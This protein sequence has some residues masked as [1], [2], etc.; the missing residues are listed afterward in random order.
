[1]EKEFIVA[2]GDLPGRS[3][4]EMYLKGIIENFF[5]N[6]TIYITYCFRDGECY[7][8]L[9]HVYLEEKDALEYMKADGFHYTFTNEGE[10]RQFYESG[11]FVKGMLTCKMTELLDK[12][13]EDYERHENYLEKEIKSYREENKRYR[14]DT[15]G[16]IEEKVSREVEYIFNDIVK[17]NLEKILNDTNKHLEK[18]K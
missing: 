4:E 8:L 17:K 11:V 18:L 2:D 3:S 15:E 1:M 5:G 6:P 12:M 7:D 9:Y 16:I 13:I 10:N 14:E